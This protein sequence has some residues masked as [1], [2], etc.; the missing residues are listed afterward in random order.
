MGKYQ[1]FDPKAEVIGQ[2]MLGFLQCLRREEVAPYLTKH[3]LTDI[4]PDQWYP[5]QKWLDVLSDLSEQ[6]AG[7][8]MFDF[9]AIGM[10]VSELSEFPPEIKTMPFA[11]VAISGGRQAYQMAH[12]GG[13]IG[14]ITGE[15]VSAKHI[16][17]CY[18]TPYPDDFW[19][20][21]LYAFARRVLSGHF[22][23]YY[24]EETPRREHG[25]E[26]TIIHVTWE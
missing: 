25:G 24:D 14:E 23:V 6:K 4:R 11:E 22:T 2:S 8:A 19:Y 21:G 3:G 9:V 16:K 13:D 12:R 26:Y 15:I 1:S 18:K 7:G 5:V 17:V 20:G 10:K